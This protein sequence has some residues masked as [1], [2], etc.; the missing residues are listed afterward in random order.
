MKIDPTIG[1][2]AP[3][4]RVS[5]VELEL[6]VARIR[7]ARVKSEGFEV[8]VHPQCRKGHLFFAG[9]DEQRAQALFDYAMDPAISVIWCARGGYGAARILPLLDKM[10]KLAKPPKKLLVGYSDVTALFEYVREKWGWQ[11]LHGPIP[12]LRK[13]CLIP[14]NEFK[15]TLQLIRS[16][17]QGT[18]T[19]NIKHT[20][21]LKFAG[22]PPKKAIEGQLVGGNL[23]V[24]TSLVG[25]PYEG[26]TKGKIVFFE[27]VDEALY[28]IDRMVCQLISSNN[29]K[30][31]KAIVLGNF[32]NCRDSIPLVLKTLPSEKNRSRI[33]ASPRPE[34]L[35]HLREK[36]DESKMIPKIFQQIQ[37]KYGIPVAYGLPVGHGPQQLPLPM[38]ARY[39]LTQAGLLEIH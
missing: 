31:A 5:A 33:I 11:T 21:C 30:G 39:R 13:F 9:T 24:W 10:T 7:S 19:K 4:S 8:R 12:G 6:G 37:E 32:L 17:L 1:I 2:V 18:L 22:A 28:R 29:L 14:E 3:S 20:T 38:G 26:K 23:T 35:T 34:E 16:K 27:D 25:T 36:L 15:A